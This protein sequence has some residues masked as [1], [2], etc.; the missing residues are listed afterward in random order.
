MH[1]QTLIDTLMAQG[2]LT[3]SQAL[4]VIEVYKRVRALKL[5]ADGWQVAHGEFFD[6][7]VIRRAWDRRHDLIIVA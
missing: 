6:R 1:R 7:E 3:E 2:D 4:E 5:G